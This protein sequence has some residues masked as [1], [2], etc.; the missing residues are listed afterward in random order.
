MAQ[1]E[2][3]VRTTRVDDDR[4]IE[5]RRK[6][7]IAGQVVSLIGFILFSLLALRFVLSLLGANRNNGFADF[8][9]SIT[10]P[11]VAPFFGLFNYDPQFGVSRFEYETL[12]AMLFYALVLGIIA[13]VVMLGRNDRV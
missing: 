1:T 13:R 11:F 3:I 4:T 5:T 6:P 8:I 12:V 2:E 7:S 9:Y 10:Y